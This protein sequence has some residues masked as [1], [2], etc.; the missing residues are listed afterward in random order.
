MKLREIPRPQNPS[1]LYSHQQISPTEL[2]TRRNICIYKTETE[3]VLRLNTCLTSNMDV[4]ASQPRILSGNIWVKGG[5]CLCLLYILAEFDLNFST[6]LNKP[7]RT[8][9]LLSIRGRPNLLKLLIGRVFMKKVASIFRVPHLLIDKYL[10]GNTW[11]LWQ[12][13]SWQY[14]QHQQLGWS[15]NLL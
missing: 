12:W 15:A 10:L 1:G 5:H 13:I 9:L 6:H 8:S 14:D 2:P 11:V 7:I 3:K 4:H